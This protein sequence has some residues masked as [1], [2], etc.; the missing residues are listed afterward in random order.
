M[1]HLPPW[2]RLF[3]TFA[4]CLLQGMAHSAPPVSEIVVG[5]Y[6]FPPIADFGP[7]Q[8]PD[9]LLPELV[10]QIEA[11]NPGVHFR[12]VHTSPK[13]RY[14]DFDAGLFD[15]I[16]F[17]NPDWGWSGRDISVS[18]PLLMDQDI[19]VALRKPG[20]GPDFFNNISHRKIVALSGYHYG[21]A[22]GETDTQALSRSLSIEFSDSNNRNL[23]LI[24]ADRPS[25]AE[26]AVI[27]R[28]YLQLHLARHPEDR[29][30]LLTSDQPDQTYLLRIIARKGGP[31]SADE[32]T[33]MLQPLIADGRYSQLV[34]KWGLQLPDNGLVGLD[35]P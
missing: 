23:Q 12:I 26:V 8:K 34:K 17:E 27:N 3:L 2:Q 13:R 22:S 24:K 19:Y 1:A 10:Q 35:Q 5:A 30:L 15:V 33:H 7:E 20:R 25:V 29:N 32:L 14:M 21:F 6:Y 4:L 9:G 28:S 18:K 31:A 16:F 11:S